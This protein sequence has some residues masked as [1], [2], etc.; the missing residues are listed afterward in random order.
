MSHSPPLSETLTLSSR[1]VARVLHG[2]S[3]ADALPAVRRP[4]VQNLVYGT[5]RD[6][7]AGD[8][9]LARLLRRPAVDPGVHAL[10][11]CALRELRHEHTAS[12]TVV[13][14]AVAACSA[15]G[16][17]AAKGLVNAVLRNYG[18]KRDELEESLAD[19]EVSRY[20]HPQWWIDRLK[21]AYP[22][23]WPGILEAGNSH[24]PMTLRVN[25]RRT[26]PAAYLQ[27]LQSL[28]IDAEM[29]GASGI[30][31]V[32]PRPVADVPGFAE[33]DVSVQDAAAQ[34]AALLL[35]LSD[36][37]RVLDACAAPGGK[38]AH[39]LEAAAVRLVALDQNAA[40][41]GRI[42][43]NLAR[44]GGTADI[45]IADAGAPD[46]W[47]DGVPFERILLDA[48]CT[49]SGVVRRHPDIKWLRRE[50]DIAGFVGQ[51][52][53]LLHA[54]WR[55]LAPGGKFLYA[56]CSVF[57]E[58]NDLQIAAFI[59]QHS[60]AHRLTLPLPRDGQL[61]PD[62]AHDGFYYALLQKR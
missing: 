54:L 3:L 41:A 58:E 25:R 55:A 49:G 30:R 17:G 22:D 6:Y 32:Q 2:D 27:R 26:T 61:L 10:L 7:G 11:L 35:D 57:P 9:V 36:D 4:G 14:Q 23:T 8:A 29:V 19:D 34:H 5:L 43:Q 51:Q 18:R 48:P 52:R 1:A 13:N 59:A 37:A 12:H 15:L 16:F 47:W 21:I 46:T 45:R 53:R 20:R 33:G 24:P 62:P 56:T 60:D 38:S 40:R 42:E 28:G 39:I 50:A 31:L 44:L